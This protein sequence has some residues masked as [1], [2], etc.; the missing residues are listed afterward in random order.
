MVQCFLLLPRIPERMNCGCAQLGCSSMRFCAGV[1]W[2]SKRLASVETLRLRENCGEVFVHATGHGSLALSRLQHLLIGSPEAASN[3]KA[4]DPTL[5][6]LLSRAEILQLLA[7]NLSS[8][9]FFF[10]PLTR[11]KHLVLNFVTLPGALSVL[12]SISHAVSLET[13]LI[14]C[15]KAGQGPGPNL[16]L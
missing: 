15:Q 12:Q 1:L 10:P 14:K 13:L 5:A 9:C 16:Q 3:S 7:A 6:W 8:N 2:V 4:F 11:L